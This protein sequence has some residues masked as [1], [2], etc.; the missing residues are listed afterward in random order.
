M[1]KHLWKIGMC[2]VM[3]ISGFS[4]QKLSAEQ[5]VQQTI[6]DLCQ[7]GT[8]D[9]ELIFLASPEDL[10]FDEGDIVLNVKGVP[11]SVQNLK[12]VGNQW[13]ATVKNANALQYCP[14]GHI[15]CRNCDQCHNQK[16]VYYIRPCKLWDPR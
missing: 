10:S 12:R 7:E 4:F 3:V 8:H 13:V 15:T 11:Y 5:Y 14:R 16:C 6:E 1:Q 9:S 2:V